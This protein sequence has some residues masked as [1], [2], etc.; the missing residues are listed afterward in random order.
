MSNLNVMLGLVYPDF[1]G[2][3][4]AFQ[5]EQINQ[6]NKLIKFNDYY[7]N[8][9]WKYITD[10]YPEYSNKG[11]KGRKDYTPTKLSTNWAKFFIQRL[12]SWQFENNPSVSCLAESLDKKAG[13]VGYKPTK[14]QLEEQEKAN[15]REQLIYKVYEENLMGEEWL[16]AAIEANKSGGVAVKLV[17]KNKRLNIIFRPRIECFPISDSDNV[18]DI[19]K[20]HFC[21]FLPENNGETLWKQ[22]FELRPLIN[23]EGEVILDENGE[24][25]MACHMLEGIYNNKLDLVELIHNAYL[26]YGDNYLDFLPLEIIPNEPELAV[27]WPTTTLMDDLIPLIDAYAMKM[28]D[29]ADSLRF[30][31]FCIRVLLNVENSNLNIKPG[32]L[33]EMMGGDKDHPVGVENLESGFN[34]KEAFELYLNEIVDS[35]HL[36]T[37]IV[38]LTP[39]QIKGMGALSG[40]AIKLMFALSVSV[41]NKRNQLWKPRIESMN[42]KILKMMKI[43]EP[44]IHDDYV[45]EYLKNEFIIRMPIP[46]NEVEQL[47]VAIKKISS[48]LS[49]I[50]NEMD[51]M[52]VENPELLLAQVL[53]EEEQLKKSE[54][55]AYVERLK[56]EGAEE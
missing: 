21:G 13:Q 19:K 52:G 33:W 25:I 39:S 4:K 24:K 8:D 42:K 16:K 22:T 45:E 2:M 49:T 18:K 53:E 27:I 9:I 37:G 20:V 34:W 40:T 28:S 11:V 55:D 23:E 48:R 5:G 12:A 54:E 38:R 36:I 30:E 32:A 17:Y 31:M 46:Q 50:K 41:T 29:A 26:G 44:G 3:H 1:F 43:Y 10:A 7:H 6:I 35:M 14:K 51:K 15:K 47:D 56:V